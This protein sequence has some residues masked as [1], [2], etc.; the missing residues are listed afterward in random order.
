LLK[1]CIPE[2]LASNSFQ[3]QLIGNSSVIDSI[4]GATMRNKLSKQYTE[5]AEQAKVDIMIL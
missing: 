2:H 1:Q 5:V 3:N 4:Q